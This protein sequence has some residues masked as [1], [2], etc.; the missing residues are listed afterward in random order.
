MPIKEVDFELNFT[1]LFKEMFSVSSQIWIK[2]IVVSLGGCCKCCKR[3][4][5]DVNPDMTIQYMYLQ[6]FLI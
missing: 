6:S 5:T 3:K 4:D 1:G 2:I